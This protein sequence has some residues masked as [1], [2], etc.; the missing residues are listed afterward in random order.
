MDVSEDIAWI[1]VS[2]EPWKLGRKAENTTKYR[3]EEAQKMSISEYMALYPGLKKPTGYHLLGIDF[4]NLYP[5]ETD[6]L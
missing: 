6:N 5:E 2:S 4:D 3:R 1:K